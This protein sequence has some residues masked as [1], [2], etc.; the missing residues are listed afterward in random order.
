MKRIILVVLAGISLFADSLQAEE[1]NKT[2]ALVN[3]VPILEA[4]L[5]KA[6]KPYQDE[7]AGSKTVELK[8]LEKVLN[9]LIEE[10]MV[11]QEAVAKNVTPAPGESEQIIGLIRSRFKSEEGFNLALKMA[12]IDEAE[13]LKRVNEKLMRVKITDWA[14]KSKIHLSQEGLDNFC[15]DYGI[16]VHA[17]H[18]LVNTEKEAVDIYQQALSGVNFSQLAATY[19]L[20]P[21]KQMCGD[22]GFFGRGQ[23]VTEFEEAAFAMNKEGELSGVV[24]TKFGYHLIR[25]IAKKEPTPEEINEIKQALINELYG[26][27]YLVI[28]EELDF[29]IKRNLEEK[30]IGKQL[31]QTYLN[32]LLELKNKAKIK[33]V[34]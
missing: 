4:K 28:G 7:I 3:D 26:R 21:S 31:Q 14:V 27:T 6:L 22:L 25:F 32:W 20:C 15:K 12:G 33:I 17:Q 16:K 19:S 11:L 18:I 8:I 10:E 24:K 30:F 1:Q 9:Q 5:Q 23:M 29:E 34:P 2:V 13:F